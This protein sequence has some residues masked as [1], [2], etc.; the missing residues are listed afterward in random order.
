MC[1]FHRQL[2]YWLQFQ[3]IAIA[4]GGARAKA[5]TPVADCREREDSQVAV[6]T[7]M[8]GAHVRNK[9]APSR[10][11]LRIRFDESLRKRIGGK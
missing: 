1:L 4:K 10:S 9:E 11:K 7:A 6:Y 8:R 5:S 2:A 3:Q